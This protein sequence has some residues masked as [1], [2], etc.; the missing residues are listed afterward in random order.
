V[1]LLVQELPKVLQLQELPKVLLTLL[2]VL[3]T[4][5]ELPKVLLT[6]QESPKVH[7][8]VLLTVQELPKLHRPCP[9]PTSPKKTLYWAS[10][11]HHAAIEIKIGLYQHMS[12]HSSSTS[13]RLQQL[14][15]IV[16]AE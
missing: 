2:T 4:V 1:L 13:R 11:S 15:C 6:V 16:T 8:P 10:L 14:D 9:T 3:L 12:M 7:R 5:Q